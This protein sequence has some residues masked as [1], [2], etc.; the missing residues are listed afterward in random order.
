MGTT[1]RCSFD[2]ATARFL[3]TLGNGFPGLLFWHNQFLCFQILKQ[4]SSGT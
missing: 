2:L 3:E 1:R 4:S